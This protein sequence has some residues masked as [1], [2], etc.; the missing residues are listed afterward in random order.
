MRL[1]YI[2]IPLVTIL[3]SG[4]GSWITN[5]GMKW[6]KSINLPTWTPPG[7]VIGT[8]W[9][10]LFILATISALIVW[11][12]AKHNNYFWWIIG[13]FLVNAV[14][15]V[16]WSFLFFGQHLIGPAIFEAG[17][18]GLSVVGLVILIWPLSRL[19]ASLL[20][21]Y[22]AWVSFATYL[23]YSIWSLNK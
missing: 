5:N 22:A 11:N 23:T 18:L 13:L 1:N 2:I 9:T 4:V 19:A 10:V 15:N 12:T 14:L 8:V 7:S 6:Y 17:L 21:P 16:G 3:T 20:I